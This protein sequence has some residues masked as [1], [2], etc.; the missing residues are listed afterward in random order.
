MLEG[1][2]LKTGQLV[3]AFSLF[4]LS[5]ASAACAETLEWVRQLG[6]SSRDEVL[7]VSADEL[8]NV[9]ISGYTHGS[10]ER[11]V[12]GINDAFVAKYDAHG[13]LQWTRQFGSGGGD[14]ANA[15]SVDG[16]GNV[17]VSGHT[18]G[19]LGGEFAGLVDAY[20]R[21]YDAA[22]M[23]QWT[24]QLG[25]SGL[26]RS[27]AV[28]ADGQ[29]NVFIS[30]YTEGNLGGIE[31]GRLDAF[32]S[33]YDDSGSFQWSR[34]LVT[35]DG[36]S[37]GSFGI[38]GDGLGNVYFSGNTGGNLGGP[39]FGGESDAF[40]SKYDAS[41]TRQWAQQLGTTSDDWSFA[42][43]ADGLGN[44][45]VS[46]NTEGDL[47][48]PNAGDRDVFVSNYDDSGTLR[49][50]RQ[51]GTSGRDESYGIS[52]DGLGNAYVSGWT[53]GSLGAR[54]NAGE[55]DAFVSKYNDSGTL[56]WTHQFGNDSDDQSRG[57]SVDGLGNVYVAGSTDGRLAGP[58]AGDW[59]L[60]VAKIAPDLPEPVTDFDADGHLD[61]RDIDALV[62]EIVAGT[63]DFHFDLS[64]DEAINHVDLTRWLNDAAIANGFAEPYLLGDANLDGTVN[65]ADLNAV[66]QNWLGQPNTW[67]LGDFNADGIVNAGDLNKI[68]LNW[69]AAIPSAT[70]SATVPE[71]R[72]FTMSLFGI[73]ATLGLRRRW[74]IHG[75][76]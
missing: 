44:V 8:G 41:G 49:W 35:N 2:E 32:I 65:G 58:H 39:H 25:T 45:F 47:A 12:S 13:T 24:Q 76:G 37:S 1:F 19:S 43:S 36:E 15:V 59:D 63:Y 70:S 52:T 40:V 61:G 5:C 46:G 69:L 48:A 56:L 34:Q 9:Y 51:I 28:S 74:S 54:P 31:S 72:T 66:G 10:L 18:E 27:F 21:K 38:S 14:R 64:G 6:T 26:D 7:G 29:G 60:F 50:T 30:G 4:V 23:L 11:P 42:V 55:R 3:V 62:G 71:P 67:Q 16:L 17:Y 68:G 22:G 33:K 53:R 20:V 75:P 57:V 73:L